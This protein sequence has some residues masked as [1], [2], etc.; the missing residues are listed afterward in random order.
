M[1]EKLTAEAFGTLL[2]LSELGRIRAVQPRIASEL[3]GHGLAEQAGGA[4][5]ITA[6]GRQFA[7]T[8]EIGQALG[9]PPSRRRRSCG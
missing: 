5:L 9:F 7:E 3:V 2:A 8:R 6:A 1:A 4:L